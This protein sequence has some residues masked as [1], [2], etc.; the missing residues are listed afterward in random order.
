MGEE[1]K[2]KYV[3]YQ[4]LHNIDIYIY[5][6]GELGRTKLTNKPARAHLQMWRTRHRKKAKKR[7]W[8]K[9]IDAEK[10]YYVC[11]LVFILADS[12]KSNRIKFNS[13]FFVK[14][15]NYCGI[16]V[17]LQSFPCL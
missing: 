7:T 12:L 10:G 6:I 3:E 4:H 14:N 16:T 9:H 5:I 11:L 1:T 2:Q 17:T 15:K 8:M 13:I